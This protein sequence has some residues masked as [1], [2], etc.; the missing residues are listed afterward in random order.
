MADADEPGDGLPPETELI[1]TTAEFDEL[2]LP[3]GL[4]R[5]HHLAAGVWGVLRVR[6]GSVRF[7]FEEGD[8]V[9]RVIVAGRSQLI[10]PEALHHIE[11]VGPVRFVLEFHRALDG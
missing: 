9:G 1:R 7:V 2:D 10:P 8:D 6:S 3:A 5:A 11:L 4:L